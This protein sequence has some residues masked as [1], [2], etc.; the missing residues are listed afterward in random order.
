MKRLSTY[1]FLCFTASTLSA[2]DL[3]DSVER[4]C[5]D[6]HKRTPL[7]I[8]EGCRP[9]NF[10]PSFATVEANYQGH[11]LPWRPAPQGPQAQKDELL[12]VVNVGSPQ[13][14]LKTILV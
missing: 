6:C 11:A 8:A 9:G 5:I 2:A 10:K 14:L 3:L 7:L 1:L 13:G 12:I 4:Y